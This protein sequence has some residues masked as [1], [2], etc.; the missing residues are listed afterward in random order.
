MWDS[1]KGRVAGVC[2]PV[3]VGLGSAAG[4]AVVAC[5]CAAISSAG[6]V[7]ARFPTGVTDEGPWLA[8]AAVREAGLHARNRTWDMY[9]IRYYV[10]HGGDWFG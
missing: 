5:G 4:W 8:Y 9:G 2:S 3:R 7:C 1:W 6:A 10:L